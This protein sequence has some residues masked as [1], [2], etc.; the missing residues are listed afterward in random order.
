MTETICF[1]QESE[2][3]MEDDWIIMGLETVLQVALA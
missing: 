3:G 1:W 2:K